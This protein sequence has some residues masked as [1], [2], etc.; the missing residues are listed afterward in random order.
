MG[1]RGLELAI[2]RSVDEGKSFEKVIALQK[3]ELNIGRREVLSIEGS[4][5]IRFTPKGVEVFVSTEK[6]GIGYPAQIDSYL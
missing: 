2:F 6:S 3:S 1:E 4:A 5:A